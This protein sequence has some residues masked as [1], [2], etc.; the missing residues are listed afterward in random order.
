MDYANQRPLLKDWQ[1]KMMDHFY[2]FQFINRSRLSIVNVSCSIRSYLIVLQVYTCHWWRST[3]SRIESCVLN[4]FWLKNDDFINVQEQ[5][6]NAVW[7]F[8]NNSITKKTETI[9]KIHRTTSTLF[10]ISI[11]NYLDLYLN[12][13]TCRIEERK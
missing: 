6:F 12:T 10:L 2:L 11:V 3:F 1:K 9:F 8:K 5:E 4:R 7:Y 13:L